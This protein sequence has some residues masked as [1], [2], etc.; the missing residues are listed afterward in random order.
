MAPDI[1]VENGIEGDGEECESEEEEEEEDG[2]DDGDEGGEGEE[3]DD[4]I[5]V[6]EDDVDEDDDEEEAVNDEDD[7][8]NEEDDLL[9]DDEAD[10]EGELLSP[11]EI[12]TF[13]SCRYVCVILHKGRFDCYRGR[14][15]RIK[16]VGVEFQRMSCF[17]HAK[18]RE[19]NDIYSSNQSAEKFHWIKTTPYE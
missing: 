15:T 1:D 19:K 2:A 12:A 4:S 8:A 14:G 11:V 10:R 6:V 7:V 18:G 9:V 5:V 3:G 13:C 16:T 17:I